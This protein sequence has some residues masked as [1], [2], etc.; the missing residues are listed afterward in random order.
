MPNNSPNSYCLLSVCALCNSYFNIISDHVRHNSAFVLEAKKPRIRGLRTKAD[1]PFQTRSARCQS[2]KPCCSSM[3][4]SVFNIEANELSG[5]LVLPHLSFHPIMSP[6][7]WKNWQEMYTLF[8][9]MEVGLYQTPVR[10]S[11]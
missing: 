1:F 5:C 8:Y 7:S 2:P 11:P 9:G 6:A 3:L 4:F 10:S